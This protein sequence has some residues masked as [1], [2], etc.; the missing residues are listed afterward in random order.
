MQCICTM[1]ECEQTMEKLT[2]GVCFTLYIVQPTKICIGALFWCIT[3]H[4]ANENMLHCYQVRRFYEFYVFFGFIF[5]IFHGVCVFFLTFCNLQ[6]FFCSDGF[7]EVFIFS[8]FC[9]LRFV[10]VYS[11][12]SV[13][14]VFFDSIVSFV[15]FVSFFLSGATAHKRDLVFYCRRRRTSILK[16]L[17][18]CRSR[19]TPIF[20]SIP[21]PCPTL[22]PHLSPSFRDL[23]HLCSFLFKFL[24]ILDWSTTESVK[25]LT[26]PPKTLPY[27][28]PSL[29]PSRPITLDFFSILDKN[30]NPKSLQFH[31]FRLH[32]VKFPCLKSCSK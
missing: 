31:S 29:Y 14:S 25:P 22:L 9:L 32:D 4:D 10:S 2:V 6:P 1:Y 27:Q 23:F 26:P 18:F 13:S 7:F 19:R 30:Q 28:T 11:V 5:T 20:C 15:F 8:Q 12:Y 17:Y 24:S 3:L 16:I 21:L